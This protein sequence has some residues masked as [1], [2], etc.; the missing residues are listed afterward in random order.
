MKV[1]A[2]CRKWAFV[3]DH[4]SSHLISSY[5]T[6]FHLRPSQ[7]RI[8]STE[9]SQESVAVYTISL[10][11]YLLSAPR[12]F[13]EENRRL[14]NWTYVRMLTRIDSLDEQSKI[15]FGPS[16][17]H[18]FVFR[19]TCRVQKLFIQNRAFNNAFAWRLAMEI[20]EIDRKRKRIFRK[21]VTYYP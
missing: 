2:P 18:Q 9:R 19:P 10:I 14:K 3:S 13:I 5:P 15:C 20:N 16:I 4:P 12:Y 8:E 11:D 1:P 7:S 17:R 21:E 6:S